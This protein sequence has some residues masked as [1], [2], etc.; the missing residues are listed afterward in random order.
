MQ[1]SVWLWSPVPSL[2]A[3][4]SMMP[5]IS[6]AKLGLMAVAQRQLWARE[7]GGDGGCGLDVCQTPQLLT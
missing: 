7:H 4:R 3:M 5:H 1:A 2:R 6:Q